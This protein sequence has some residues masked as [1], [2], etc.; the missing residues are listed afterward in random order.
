MIHYA[1]RC[2]SRGLA[3]S[4]RVYVELSELAGEADLADV[5]ANNR[6]WVAERSAADPDYFKKLV[7][8]D[9]PKCASR[10]VRGQAL[11]GLTCVLA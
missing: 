2:A 4:S 11:E 5:I 7:R 8:H 3:S 1:L 6:A 10:D 9:K